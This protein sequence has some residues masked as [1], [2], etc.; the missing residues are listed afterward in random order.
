MIGTAAGTSCGGGAGRVLASSRRQWRQGK[1]VLVHGD[2]AA[3]QCRE[4]CLGSFNFARDCRAV[5][6][7]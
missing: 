7:I 3:I 2:S 6:A 1:N 4:C 5:T